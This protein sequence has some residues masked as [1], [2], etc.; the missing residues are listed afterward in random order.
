[1]HKE[2][3]KERYLRKLILKSLFHLLISFQAHSE[4]KAKQTTWNMA[5]FFILMPIRAAHGLISH[6]ITADLDTKGDLLNIS[7]AI[8]SKCQ[9]GDRINV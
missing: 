9:S 7:G 4:A 2:L 6:L 3:S 8:T 5:L 1:M